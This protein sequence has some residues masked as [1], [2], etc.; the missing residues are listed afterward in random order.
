MPPCPKN[1]DGKPVKFMLGEPTDCTVAVI[2]DDR[3]RTRSATSVLVDELFRRIET[4]WP[5]T[6]S[7]APLN[8]DEKDEVLTWR[9]S[10][11][12]KSIS[13]G[14]GSDVEYCT[15]DCPPI[16][17]LVPDPETVRTTRLNCCDAAFVL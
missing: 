2:R 10:T 1:S 14:V 4:C 7:A 9:L 6:R 5:G 3:S 8:E 17:R 15:V 13:N 16:T 11:W 12:R